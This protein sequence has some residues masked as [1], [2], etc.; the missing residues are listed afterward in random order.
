VNLFDNTQLG[1]EKAIAGASMRQTAIA[2]NIANANTPN[3]QRKDVDFHSALQTAMS[4]GSR[5]AV[6]NLTFSETADQ[7]TTMRVDGNGVDIDA[8]SAT[9]AQNGME[10][11]ALVSVSRGRTDILR[12]A[13]GL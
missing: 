2:G 6:Q 1:L 7:G 8:E 3:Y 5:D 12:A 11:E 9:L 10:Y 4:S 13:M